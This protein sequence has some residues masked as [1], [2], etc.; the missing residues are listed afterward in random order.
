WFRYVDA[1]VINGS[2]ASAYAQIETSLDEVCGELAP[3]RCR[4]LTD[5]IAWFPMPMRALLRDRYRA[6]DERARARLLEVRTRRFYRMRH[7]MRT[8]CETFAGHLTC[9]ADFPE[10][11]Q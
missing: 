6:V 4:D 10:P 3:D 1:P 9:V 5:R 11:G 8:R 7:L 2:R